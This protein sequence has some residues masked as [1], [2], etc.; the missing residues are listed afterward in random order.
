MWEWAFWLISLIWHFGFANQTQSRFATGCWGTEIT[1]GQI[2]ED[3]C[4][5]S[6]WL[7]T[8]VQ[9]DNLARVQEGSWEFAQLVHVRLLWPCP[10]RCP[11]GGSPVVWGWVARCYG[12]SGLCTLG[13]RA[14]FEL[15]CCTEFCDPSEYVIIG[16]DVAHCLHVCGQQQLRREKTETE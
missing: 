13:V 14:W 10:S 12:R 11:V 8:L 16:G 1:V 2:Q 4:V 3:L 15:Q 9:L 5:F 7:R 6:S